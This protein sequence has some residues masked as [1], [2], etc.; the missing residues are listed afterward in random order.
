MRRLN[1]FFLSVFAVRVIYEPVEEHRGGRLLQSTRA[2]LLNHFFE[3][4]LTRHFV[5]GCPV[6]LAK[7]IADN[8]MEI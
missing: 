1:T 3:P 8:S 4:F 6:A 2:Q 5:L 7:R